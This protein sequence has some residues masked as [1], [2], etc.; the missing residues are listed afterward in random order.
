[1]TNGPFA[2]LTLRVN[3][4]LSTSDHCLTRNLNVCRFSYAAQKYVDECQNKT[5]FPLWR[6]CTEATPHAAGHGGIGALMENV[7]LSPGDPLFWLHHTYLD[8]L[9]YDWQ[10]VSPSTRT[11][12]I[13]GTNQFLTAPS[14]QGGLNGEL[15][16]VDNGTMNVYMPPDA[17]TTEIVDSYCGVYQPNAP[18]GAFPGNPSITNYYG[19]GG[20]VTTLNHTLWSFGLYPNATANDVMDLHGAFVCAEYV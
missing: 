2:N 12:A 3:G 15:Y 7:A 11:Y 14:L 10:A 20:N 5:T 13:G 19:D 9:W 16:Y 6:T 18:G 4:N 17:N 1:V 8:K